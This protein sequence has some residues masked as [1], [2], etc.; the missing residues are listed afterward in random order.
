MQ[1]VNARSLPVAFKSSIVL[2][3][4][5]TPLRSVSAT[6]RQP[7]A[8]RSRQHSAGAPQALFGRLFG[9]ATKMAS[10]KSVEEAKTE[11]LEFIS[12]LKRGVDATEEDKQQVDAMAQ[13]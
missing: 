3:N 2:R 11:L 13:V 4:G 1:V 6:P 10:G 7:R 8:A 9:G 12:G 5:S